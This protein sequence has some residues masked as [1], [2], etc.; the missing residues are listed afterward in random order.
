MSNNISSLPQLNRHESEISDY[1]TDGEKGDVKHLDSTTK[2]DTIIEEDEDGNV[3]LAAYNQSK[4]EGEIV[5]PSFVLR[6]K[7]TTVDT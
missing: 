4:L 6:S 2:P 1:T 3:G 5:C 7:L